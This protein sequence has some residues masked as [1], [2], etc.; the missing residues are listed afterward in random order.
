MGGIVGRQGTLTVIKDLGLKEPYVGQVPM[1]SGEIAEDLTY[2]FAKSEQIPSAVSLGVLVDTDGSVRAAGGFIVQLLPNTDESTAISIEENIKKMKSVSELIDEKKS[3]D[4]L[5]DLV[6]P[7]FKL[8]SLAKSQVSYHCSC[9][10]KKLETVIVNLG[11]EQA[12]D[13]LKENGKIELIC[14]YCK[15]KYEFSEQETMQILENAHK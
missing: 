9:S 7:G 11:K 4:E 1:V 6:L 2:Y 5:L 10:R 13:M 14:Q 15:K 8:K 12:Q 3:P